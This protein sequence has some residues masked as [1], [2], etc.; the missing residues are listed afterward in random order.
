MELAHIK[1]G[2]E[3]G[4]KHKAGVASWTIM[5][6]NVLLKAMKHESLIKSSCVLYKQ[7]TK[8]HYEV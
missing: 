4:Y 6:I 5:R 2:L 1:Y 8:I 3:D 7:T